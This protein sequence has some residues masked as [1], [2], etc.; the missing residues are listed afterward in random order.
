MEA[1]RAAVRKIACSFGPGYFQEQVDNGGNAE[2]AAH[3]HL[4]AA[5]DMTDKACRLYDTAAEVGELANMAEYLGAE[6]GLQ[7]LNAASAYRAPTDASRGSEPSLISRVRARWT[8]YVVAPI[9]IA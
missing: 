4:T 8:Q 3:I 2:A 9:Q 1:L 5:V 6:S 7:A